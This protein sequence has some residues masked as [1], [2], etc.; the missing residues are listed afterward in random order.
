[1]LAGIQRSLN[2][3]VLPQHFR[4][5]TYSRSEHIN[6]MSKIHQAVFRSVT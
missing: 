1:M 6:H 5:L 3:Q 2:N 4:L